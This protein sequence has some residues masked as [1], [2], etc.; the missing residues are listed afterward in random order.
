MVR[1][2]CVLLA[3]ILISGAEGLA[4]S[5]SGGNAGGLGSGTLSTS[6]SSGGTSGL[7]AGGLSSGA[8]SAAGSRTSTGATG[9][10]LGGG[11][12]GASRGASTQQGTQFG[13]T[14]SQFNMGDGTLGQQIGQNQFVGQSN[15]QGFVGNRFAGQNN[16]QG[17]ASNFAGLQNIANQNQRN[18]AGGTGTGT[19]QSLIRPQLRVDFTTPTFPVPQIESLAVERLSS[20]P[21]ANGVQL[22]LNGDGVATLRGAVAT[23]NDRRVLEAFVR[24]EP[25]VRDVK[26]EVTVLP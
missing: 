26:N 3:G 7:S 5:R 23:E 15:N 9:T 22:S 14:Q 20:L 10:S 25:G 16:T 13:Q 19:R 17:T 24:M 8:S 6:Q 21:N 2:A 4:Q 18:G 1:F 11:G 12:G